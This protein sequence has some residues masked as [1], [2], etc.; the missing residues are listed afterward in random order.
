VRAGYAHL[1]LRQ[2]LKPSMRS[3]MHLWQGIS[4][5]PSRRERVSIARLSDVKRLHAGDQSRGD[6]GKR[7]PKER[8]IALRYNPALF[9]SA[10]ECSAALD[11]ELWIP[12]SLTAAL[13]RRIV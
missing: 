3:L 8:R 10:G 9:Q 1:R 6:V 5:E 11:T 13:L 2:F 7:S 4:A 12:I